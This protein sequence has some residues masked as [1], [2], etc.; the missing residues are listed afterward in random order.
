MSHDPTPDAQDET[1][2][3]EEH[4]HT[5]DGAIPEESIEKAR[6]HEA[7]SPTE[8]PGDERPREE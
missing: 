7:S 3:D 1:V 8:E 4:A 6:A 5:A 2:T